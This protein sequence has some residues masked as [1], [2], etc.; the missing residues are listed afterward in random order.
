MSNEKIIGELSEKLD[1]PS[2]QIEA[3]L[4]ALS[5]CIRE[6]CCD[7]DTVAI[8]GFGTFQPVKYPEKVQTDLSSGEQMLMPPIV[9]VE[10]KSSV[11][12]RKRLSK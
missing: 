3:A 8:P 2:S 7:L 4:S 11:V 12:L 6:Y 9:E 1:I 10:F 5:H